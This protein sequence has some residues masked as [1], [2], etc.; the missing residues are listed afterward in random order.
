MKKYYAAIVED[1]KEIMINQEQMIQNYKY[2]L[3][4][5]KS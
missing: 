5:L 3:D 1:Y 2:E 4:L